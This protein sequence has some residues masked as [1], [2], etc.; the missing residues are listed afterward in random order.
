MSISSEWIEEYGQHRKTKDGD[1]FAGADKMRG[2]RSPSEC[3]LVLLET[4]ATVTGPAWD[5]SK[6]D[7]DA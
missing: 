7:K 5:R 3:W 4:Q 6:V 1:S 2:A